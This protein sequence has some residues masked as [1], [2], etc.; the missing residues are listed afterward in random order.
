MEYSLFEAYQTLKLKRGER[1]LADRY[2]TLC[3]VYD[4]YITAYTS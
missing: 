1:D 4:S 2:V 3:T